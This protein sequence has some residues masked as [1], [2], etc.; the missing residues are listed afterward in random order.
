[1][2][3]GPRAGGTAALCDVSATMEMV[4]GAMERGCACTIAAEELGGG[5]QIPA[6]SGQLSSVVDFPLPSSW[7]ADASFMASMAAQWGAGV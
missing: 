2:V 4:A 7:P 5:A 6:H 3:G 1:M